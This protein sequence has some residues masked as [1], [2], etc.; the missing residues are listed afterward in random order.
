[1][2]G[3]RGD[4][5]RVIQKEAASAAKGL[6][7]ISDLDV[8]KKTIASTIDL[9]GAPERVAMA[10]DINAPIPGLAPGCGDV[11]QWLKQ[12]NAVSTDTSSLID[13]HRRGYYTYSQWNTLHRYVQPDENW[14]NR[15][16]E[17]FLKLWE[18]IRP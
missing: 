13:L 15:N 11:N 5:A 14:S 12:T 16:L 18:K 9:L 2:E 3:G 17:H 1:M 4:E 10:S 6:T 7:C 8:F